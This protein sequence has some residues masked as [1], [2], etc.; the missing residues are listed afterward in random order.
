VPVFLVR[1]AD[2]LSRTDWRQPDELRPLTKRGT[3]QAEGLADLLAGAGTRRILSSPSARCRL[4]MAPLAERLGFEIEVAND[5]LEGAQGDKAV[6][7]TER[8]AKRKSGV[9]LCTHGDV[10]PDVVRRLAAKGMKLHDELKW[11]KGSAWEL[12]WNGERFTDAT[13]HPPAA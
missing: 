8:V 4:T 3:K 7:F 12:T 11:P 6:A 10:I 1:H 5:L 2:A 9:V 13:F